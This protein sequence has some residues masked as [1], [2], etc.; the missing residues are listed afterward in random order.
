MLWSALQVDWN[1]I[2]EMDSNLKEGRELT[3]LYNELLRTL[4]KDYLNI[5]NVSI[6]RVHIY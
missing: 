5:E 6:A 1:T 4:P 3:I 2:Q